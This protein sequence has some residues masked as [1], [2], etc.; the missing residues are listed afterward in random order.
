MSSV[1]NKVHFKVLNTFLHWHIK[2]KGSP[3]VKKPGRLF[4]ISLPL[5]TAPTPFFRRWK[6][7]GSVRP[8]PPQARQYFTKA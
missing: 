8:L 6:I 3:P 2:K 4:G 5:Q 1:L 7:G